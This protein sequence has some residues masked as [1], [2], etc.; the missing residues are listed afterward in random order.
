LIN[1]IKRRVKLRKTATILFL[2][3]LFT[4][5][6]F[7]QA[8]EQKTNS[9]KDSIRLLTTSPVLDSTNFITSDEK[10]CIGSLTKIN[11]HGDYIY[12][13]GVWEEGKEDEDA[14][15]FYCQ[16]VKSEKPYPYLCV[17]SD[18]YEFI[19]QLMG[20]DAVDG[21]Y[22]IGIYGVDKLEE[23]IKKI[24][25]AYVRELEIEV[26]DIDNELVATFWKY[27]LAT[28]YYVRFESDKIK[29]EVILSVIPIE[30]EIKKQ[31]KEREK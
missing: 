22:K 7:P 16:L 29:R 12:L 17:Y 14:R 25:T 24:G 13:F 31:N 8:D 23:T 30:R 19:A 9:K 11:L 28:E 15:L 10:F 20:V 4:G 26:Y 27:I 1:S 3:V 6:A 18:K 21:G 5:F 2:L